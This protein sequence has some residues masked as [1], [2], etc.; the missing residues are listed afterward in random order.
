M[1]TTRHRDDGQTVKRPPVRTGHGRDP[2][3][4]G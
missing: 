1:R 2:E 3:T 4:I